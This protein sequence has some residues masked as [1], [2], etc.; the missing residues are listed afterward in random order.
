MTSSRHKLRGIPAQGPDLQVEGSVEREAFPGYGRSVIRRKSNV[1]QAE[2]DDD[3]KGNSDEMGWSRMGSE[4]VD[5]VKD[6]IVVFWYH[7]LSC[8]LL[9]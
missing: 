3:V 1:G 2:K 5:Q 8:K 4:T 9:R 7:V 6:G